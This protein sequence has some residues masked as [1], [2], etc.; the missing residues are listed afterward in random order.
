MHVVGDYM[1][2]RKMA[3][4]T[5]DPNFGFTEMFQS[6]SFHYT[7]DINLLGSSTATVTDLKGIGAHCEVPKALSIE[8]LEFVEDPASKG[9]IYTAFGTFIPW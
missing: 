3:A 2:P 4:L 1:M 9:T 6:S 8:Y 5:N 7:D